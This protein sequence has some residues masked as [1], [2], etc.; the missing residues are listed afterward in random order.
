M[1]DVTTR[2]GLDAA[3]TYLRKPFRLT[4]EDGLPE[5][6]LEAAT[7]KPHLYRR[8][9]VR[10]RLLPVLAALPEEF[11]RVVTVERSVSFHATPYAT[12]LS[13]P[14]PD[15]IVWEHG[16]RAFAIRQWEAGR[17]GPII[18]WEIDLG[19]IAVEL[20]EAAAF[21]GVV[22]HEL[23]HVYLGHDVHGWQLSDEE[24]QRVE[25]EAVA[26]AC[27]FGFRPETEA[28]L[29]ANSDLW[30]DTVETGRLPD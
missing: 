26:C 21:S 13:M 25:D 5:Y 12:G 15:D 20:Y 28:W 9:A 11:F 2:V 24:W 19:R 1:S 6:P 17:D 23:C 18:G 16:S 3:R 22:A 7:S 30:G 29:A 27:Q 8:R 14:P 4:V 10:G